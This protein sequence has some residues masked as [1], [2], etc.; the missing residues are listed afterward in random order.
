[1]RITKDAARAVA[2]FAA[3]GL[4]LM[5]AGPAG[6]VGGDGTCHGPAATLS[7][8]DCSSFRVAKAQWRA[9]KPAKPAKI[10]GKQG[11]AERK[12]YK[13]AMRA[14]KAQRDALFAQYGIS[15]VK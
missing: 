3:A 11:K 14:W 15:V 9:A 1:M 2:G 10:A 7:A 5:G 8:Q 12:A 6:A 13:A 4:L